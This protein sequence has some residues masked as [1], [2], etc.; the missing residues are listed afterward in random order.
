MPVVGWIRSA[1]L[2]CA[3]LLFGCPASTPECPTATV[4]PEPVEIPAG[5]SQATLI[6]MVENPSP[7]SDLAVLTELTAVS[8][9]IEEPFAIVTDFDQPIAHETTYTCAIDRVGEVEVCVNAKFVEEGDAG[10]PDAGMPDDGGVPEGG[11]PEGGVAEAGVVGAGGS[12]VGSSEAYLGKPHVRLT[13]PL[14]CSETQCTTVVCPELRN[15][16]PAIESLTVDPMEVPEGGT[17]TV[18]VVAED[19]DDNPEPLNTLFTASAGSFADPTAS[20]TTY[21]CDPDVGGIIEV[22]ALVSD[23]DDACGEI[24]RC[25][26]VLCPGTP[27]ENTCPVVASFTATPMTIQPGSTTAQISIDVTDPDDFPGELMTELS[28]ETGVFDDRFVTET[29]FTCG[30]AGPVEMCIDVTDGDETC[31]QQRCITVQCPSD[32]PPNLCPQ[33]FVLNAIPSRIPS[34]QTSTMIQSRGQDT[35]ML[36]FPLTLSLR[37]LWGTITDDE[38]IQQPNNVVAQ[39]AMYICT[40]PGEV[41]ICVDAT[42]GACVKTLCIEVE[43][44]DDI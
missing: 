40:L 42:D 16:C 28:S 44:P 2:G 35:D 27:G 10:I 14:E 21:A 4:T 19:P 9:S 18:R 17:T 11:M 29:T 1:L 32:I 8:G 25:A 5:Q 22:C 38:N 20:E 31:N 39:N 33:L 7:E 15:E 13:L 34:G 12:S 37:A 36:P 41:E 43:C 24:R 30:E 6:V 3:L 26:Q 23:G